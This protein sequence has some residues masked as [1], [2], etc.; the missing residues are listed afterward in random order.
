[1]KNKGFTLIELLIV[2]GIIAILAAI[3]FVAID[4]ARRFAE[5]RNAERWAEVNALLN[6]YLT[7]LV[8]NKGTPVVSS[9]A[10]TYY[11]IG[12]G[13]GVGSCPAQA[14]SAHLNLSGLVD[15]YIAS[16]PTDPSGG[17]AAETAYYFFK[18][19]NGRI[20]IGACNAELGETI[21]VTR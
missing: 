17:T 3:L 20:T 5:A 11:L 15:Q 10:N 18:S 4:P 6:A 7:Y 2:I 14:T 13:S 21:S 8:D 9:I 16:V 1:M 19:T 12:T